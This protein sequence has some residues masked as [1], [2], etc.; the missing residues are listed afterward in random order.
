M[1]YKNHQKVNLESEP[2]YKAKKAEFE[3]LLSGKKYIVLSTGDKT[4]INV[5]GWREPDRTHALPFRVKRASV[6]GLSVDEWAYCER[7]PRTLANNEVKYDNAPFMVTRKMII[8]V[9]EKEKLFFLMYVA[10]FL[11]NG[12]L[13]LIDEVQDA[14][15]EA[16]KK[17]ETS[18]VDFFLFNKKYS[19]LSEGGMRCIARAFAISGVS[20]MTRSQV[21]LALSKVIDVATKSKDESR[22]QNAFFA[23]IKDDSSVFLRSVVQEAIDLNILGFV[24]KEMAW[25]YLDSKGKPSSKIMDVDP[26][27]AKNSV[28]RLVDLADYFSVNDAAAK[29]ILYATRYYIDPDIDFKNYLAKSVENFVVAL[30]LQP[31]GTKA[32]NVELLKSYIEENNGKVRFP[33][34]VLVLNGLADP[35]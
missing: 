26:V 31:A 12:Q 22:D 34:E 19:P 10:P 28:K 32:A 14:E 20:E 23:A 2:L 3:S 13:I 1:L 27:I 33:T 5:T 11:D 30:G 15:K 18:S 6:D 17:A 25:Y 9:A 24:E 7:A 35:D 21:A 16:E 4:V 29:T 8:P